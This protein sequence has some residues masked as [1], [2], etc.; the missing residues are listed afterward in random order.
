MRLLVLV[1][2]MICV[3]GC[4]GGASQTAH[5]N[6][7]GMHVYPGGT[8]GWYELRSDD[9]YRFSMPGLP[10]Q[11][12]VVELNFGGTAVRQHHFDLRAEAGSRGFIARVFDARSLSAEARESLRREALSLFQTDRTEIRSRRMVPRPRGAP[13]EELSIEGYT[14]VHD[15][16]ARSFIEGGF[17]FVMLTVMQT[18]SGAPTDAR[19]FFD[20]VAVR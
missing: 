4:A 16:L 1:S 3:G 10:Q 2:S 12:E 8:P 18:G 6:S 20:S 9:G 11:S 17:V 7:L 5:L 14:D 19:M 13:V 15:G